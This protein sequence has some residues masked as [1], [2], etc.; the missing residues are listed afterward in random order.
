MGSYKE[1]PGFAIAKPGS[2]FLDGEYAQKAQDGGHQNQHDANR[3]NVLNNR[4]KETF[5]LELTVVG[6]FVRQ[7][8]RLNDVANKNTSEQCYDGHE[9]AVRQEIEHIQEGHA[10]DGDMTQNAKTQCRR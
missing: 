1:S 7:G 4:L 8:L 2:V 9:D 5:A 3:C 6:N 10:G